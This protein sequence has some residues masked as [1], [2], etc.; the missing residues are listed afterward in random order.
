MTSPICACR[1]VTDKDVRPGPVVNVVAYS[2][3]SSA[4]SRRWSAAVGTGVSSAASPD[5]VRFMPGT[6][7]TGGVLEVSAGKPCGLDQVHAP[8]DARAGPG[9]RPRGGRG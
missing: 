1:L 9:R 6:V 4:A 8:G 2:R 5:W 7:V 3:G